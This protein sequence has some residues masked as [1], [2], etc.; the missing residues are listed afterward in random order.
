MD[1]LRSFKNH[2]KLIYSEHVRERLEEL[3]EVISK[4]EQLLQ[5][6]IL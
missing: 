3:D 5:T 4:S 2:I 1:K 6:L